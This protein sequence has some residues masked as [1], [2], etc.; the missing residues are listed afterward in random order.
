VKEANRLAQ[1]MFVEHVRE[2]DTSGLNLSPSATTGTSSYG[3]TSTGT[4]I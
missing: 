3:T 1:Q 4:S 2:G